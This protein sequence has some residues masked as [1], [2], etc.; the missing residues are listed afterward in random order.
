LE[1]TT[2]WI[3]NYE[4]WYNKA[5][6]NLV[7][8]YALDNY[9]IFKKQEKLPNKET[10]LIITFSQDIFINNLNY[11]EDRLKQNGILAIICEDFRMGNGLIGSQA[12]EIEKIFR[13][14]TKLKIKE[15]IIISFE[16]GPLS[17]KTENLEINHKYV[18]IFQKE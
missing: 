4:D 17:A 5:L 13:T 10:T 1:S 3:F 2:V 18:M 14:N 6:S 12:V 15:I 7:K 8:R 9:S 11:L 16:D